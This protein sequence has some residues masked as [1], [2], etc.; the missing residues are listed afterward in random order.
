VETLSCQTVVGVAAKPE[1]Y[2]SADF[3]GRTLKFPVNASS[4]GHVMC[5][6]RRASRIGA[7]LFGSDAGR[8]K[9]FKALDIAR[10]R[11]LVWRIS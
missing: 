11:K 6:R 5:I 9:Q 7:I 8:A 1:L 4:T 10:W 2:D 3:Y